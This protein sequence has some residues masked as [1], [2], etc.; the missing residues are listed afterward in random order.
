MSL[1]VLTPSPAAGIYAIQE[2]SWSLQPDQG[3]RAVLVPLHGGAT[4]A[5]QLS[6][7]AVQPVL[8]QLLGGPGQ[9]SSVAMLAL[10]VSAHSAHSATLAR[11]RVLGRPCLRLQ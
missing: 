1:D 5:V 8:Q 2:G 11:E 7:L 9:A 10:L 3:L 6:A 4:V